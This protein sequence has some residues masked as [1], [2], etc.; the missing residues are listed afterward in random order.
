MHGFKLPYGMTQKIN[1]FHAY[2]LKVWYGVKQE[3]NDL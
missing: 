1:G 2:S 3:L